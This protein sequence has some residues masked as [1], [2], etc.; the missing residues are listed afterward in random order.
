MRREL[1]EG[2]RGLDLCEGEVGHE[3]FS[4]GPVEVVFKRLEFLLEGHYVVKRDL[5]GAVIDFVE[6]AIFCCSSLVVI[7]CV[8]GS[9]EGRGDRR[10]PIRCG[11]LD[12]RGCVQGFVDDGRRCGRLVWSLSD[13]GVRRSYT[14]H[15]MDR[16]NVAFPTQVHIDLMG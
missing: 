4:N 12:R 14:G 11:C 6:S 9:G 3:P 15:T 7:V 16:E 2:S 1:V 13:C 10:V 5:D 8:W